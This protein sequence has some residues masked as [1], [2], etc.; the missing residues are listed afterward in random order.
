MNVKK[1]DKYSDSVT[2]WKNTI[3]TRYEIRKTKKQKADFIEMLSE[4]FGKNMSVERSGS[5]RNIIIGDIE[6]AKIIFTAH[7]DTCV[8]LPFPNFI[9]P[10]N[11]F[12]YVMYQ[13]VITLLLLL[14]SVLLAGVAAYLFASFIITELTMFASVTAIVWL[15]V[16]GPANR[17]TANDNTSGVI[18]VLALTDSIGS[19]NSRNI[20][21]VLFD[22]EEKGMFG[23]SAFARAHRNQRDA[24]VVVNFDCVS[25][26]DTMLMTFTKKARGQKIY[27]TIADRSEEYLSEYG[28]NP[29]VMSSSRAFYPSDQVNFKNGIAV[30]AMNKK[31]F[32]GYYVDKIHTNADTVFDEKNIA[33]LVHF[34]SESV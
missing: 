8:N 17:N 31:K 3:F 28:K 22:N 12:I 19:I 5:S 20:A 33:A 24:A 13:L 14:P 16:A 18:T 6:N 27:E 4:H 21:F 30:A 9:T 29:L 26:G 15:I 7:Y 10:M 11:P 32:I 25:D 34:W 1:T 2:R 23:S